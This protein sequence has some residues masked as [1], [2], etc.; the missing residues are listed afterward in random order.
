MSCLKL[1]SLLSLVKKVFPPNHTIF[2]LLI[3]S[4]AFSIAKATLVIAPIASIVVLSFLF[5]I[6]IIFST[7]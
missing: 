1:N 7:A 3:I 6:S 4:G 5:A 2:I